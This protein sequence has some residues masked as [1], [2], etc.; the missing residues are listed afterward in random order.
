MN[1]FYLG[2]RNLQTDMNIYD[3]NSAFLAG[4]VFKNLD[5]P[6]KNKRMPVLM[7]KNQ[8]EALMMEI[9]KYGLVVHDLDLYLDVY[10]DD[11]NAISLRKKYLKEYKELI[12]SY[13][14]MY[15]PFILE[16]DE[17]NKTPFPWSTTSFP[18]GCK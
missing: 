12:N 14:S 15:P 16:S 18:W 4:T 17:L 9:Q 3:P 11:E 5:V 1:N 6:Y 13:Q 10:P 7:P 8:R 2:T